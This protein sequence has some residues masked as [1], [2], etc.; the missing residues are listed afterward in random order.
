MFLNMEIVSL[1]LCLK[2]LNSSVKMNC[3]VECEQSK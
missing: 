3:K 1:D 2:Q